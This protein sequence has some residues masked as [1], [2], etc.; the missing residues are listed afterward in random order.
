[1]PF[2]YSTLSADT[3]YA[4]Y[5]PSVGEISIIEK[6]ILIKGGANIMPFRG[7]NTPCGAKTEITDEELDLLEKDYHFKEHVRFGF[8]KVERSSVDIDRVVRDMKDKDKSAPRT[9]DDP[10]FQGN[11]TTVPMSD[12]PDR[13]RNRR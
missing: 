8:I 3:A 2:I 1:M 6:T 4:V 7:D 11:A 13:K 10:E 9:P 5:A 12:S